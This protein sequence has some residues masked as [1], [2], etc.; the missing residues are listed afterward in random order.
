[1]KQLP[2]IYLLIISLLAGFSSL[3]QQKVYLT[4]ATVH[5]GN[6]TLLNDATVAIDSGKI[7]LVQQSPSFK[8]D[9]TMGKVIDC[10]GKHIYPGLIAL[11]TYLG[12]SEV[13]AVR[14]TN[15]M[16]EQ[17]GFN[18]NARTIIA[19]NA[20]SKVI[21]TVRSNGILYTQICPQGNRISGTSAV[22]QLDA[23]NWEDAA[24]KKE[25]GIWLNWPSQFRMKGWW[26]DPQ[27]YEPNKDYDKQ[28]QE[29]KTYF[30]EA[31]AYKGETV[32]KK[33]LRFEAMK[34]VVS[35]TQ[36]L[37]V[38]AWYVQELLH[39]IAF[40]EE[41]K[42]KLVI[43]GGQD[44]YRI[45]DILAQ[46]KIPVILDR[47]HELPL[48]DDDDVNQPYKTPSIL[49]KAGVQFALSMEGF[50]Q[51]RN[52]P[53]V[54]GTATAYGLT[55]EEA[56]AAITSSPAAILGIED[57]AGTIEVGKSA[58]LIVSSGDVLDMRTSNIEQAFINGRPV[59]LNNKQKDLYNKYK[60]KYGL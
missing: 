29:I 23:W 35:G 27:G 32:D 49:Q 17:G 57:K 20:E 33:N 8:T 56:L 48:H 28:V 60:Q 44:S 47:L 55:K 11:N 36:N 51:V 2:I 38:R 13:E 34:S 3:A 4:H 46:K 15:D 19:Y 39:A 10:T 40:A 53:F 22:V 50:W 12:L 59:D 41:F 45:A 1:M 21:P 54:A 43:V 18:P 5:V 52:L 24:V 58:S 16:A 31:Q 37:Y 42:L 30:A 25:D 9:E 6:G 14:A 26:G 7:V